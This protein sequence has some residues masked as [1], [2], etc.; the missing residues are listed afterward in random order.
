MLIVKDLP[1]I[2]QN[3]TPANFLEHAYIAQYGMCILLTQSNR[4][5]QNYVSNMMALGM[6]DAKVLSKEHLFSADILP[7]AIIIQHPNW[8]TRRGGIHEAVKIESNPRHQI[9]AL[10]FG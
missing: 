2:T 3:T 6:V 4:N 1:K 5:F 10:S 8:T 7:K 9:V